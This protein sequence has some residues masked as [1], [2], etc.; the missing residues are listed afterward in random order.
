MKTKILELPALALLALSTLNLQLSTAFAQ[1]TAFTYQGRLNDSDRSGNGN[2][3]VGF[4][5]FDAAGGGIMI[6]GPLTNTVSVS[7]GLFTTTVDF[8]AAAFDGNARWLEVAVRTNGAAAFAAL[9]PRQQLAPTPYAVYAPSAGAASTASMASSIAAN[10]VYNASLQA[11]SITTDKILDGTITDADIAATGISGGKILGGDL[12]AQRLEVGTN[13]ILNGT[14]ATIAGGSTNTVNA[15]YAAVGGGYHNTIQTNALYS[16]IGGGNNNTIQT[17]AQSAVIGGGYNNTIQWNASS[18]TISGGYGN[19]IQPYAYYSIIGGGYYNT[20]QTNTAYS[21]I[22]AGY[23]NVIQPSAYYAAIGGGGYNTIQPSTYYATIAGGRN[24]TIQSNLQYATI[25]GGYYNSIRAY[26]SYSTIAGG[27][28]NTIHTNT[29]NATIGGGYLNTIQTN[30]GYATIGGGYG[31]EIRGRGASISGGESNLAETNTYDVNI[32]GGYGNKIQAGTAY[33]AIGGGYQNLIEPQVDNAGI[34]SGWANRIAYGAQNCAIAGG[35]QNIIQTN[36]ANCTISGGY[37]N[38]IQSN[39]SSSAVVG[40][41]LNTIQPLAQYATV[42]GGYL[43]TAGA[44]YSLAAGQQA[45]AVHNGSFVWADYSAYAPF[46]STSSN[47]FLIRATGG[48]GIGTTA[49]DNPLTVVSVGGTSG[50]VGANP[51]VV[52]RFRQSGAGTTA[53]SIDAN[54]GQDAALYLAENGSAAWDIRHSPGVAHELDILYRGPGGPLAAFQL[55]TNGYLR[56]AGYLTQGSDRNLK[57][58][59]VPVD[60]REILQHLV[61]L[62]ITSWTYR[63]EGVPHMGPMAQDFYAAFGLGGDDKHIATIDADGVALAAIQGLNQKLDDLQTAL[64]R[65][66]AENAELKARLEKLEN[67]L[68]G[69][70]E[71]AN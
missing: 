24:G 60:S 2:Y 7:N 26:A 71:S 15:N 13:H 6:A 62:P 53:I 48:V 30:A 70:T 69:K 1:G 46:T 58:D 67:L 3:D 4:T 41:Y 47:Q 68:I 61:S 8:G 64:D 66:D 35:H 20:I 65:R 29:Q 38:T 37:Q 36:A 54:S 33:A 16:A 50:G 34:G 11:N 45:Q 32:G 12:Q 55:R 52:G 18:A 51:E 28:N 5:L 56:I 49:P 42:C 44:R 27:N 19:I 22:G 63:S 10:T 31:N 17:N 40:G 57:Q 21:V 39:A 25:G 9:S 43:N 23:Q 59:F 14:L